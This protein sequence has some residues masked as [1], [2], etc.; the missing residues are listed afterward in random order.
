MKQHRFSLTNKGYAVPE[1]LLN[2]DEET[3]K[4]KEENIRK[5]SNY[6]SPSMIYAKQSIY[7]R[8]SSEFGNDQMSNKEINK[9]KY[10]EN[11]KK[12]K[13]TFSNMKEPRSSLG[14]SIL[15]ERRKTMVNTLNLIKPKVIEKKET[16]GIYLKDVVNISI[17]Y[18]KKKNSKN[19]IKK[20]YDSIV[21]RIKKT[22]KQEMVHLE[23][24]FEEERIKKHH[25]EIN[26]K[27]QLEK[28]S[29][30]PLFILNSNSVNIL[31][32]KATM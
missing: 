3:K 24:K 16:G 28:I 17:E 11:L 20:N 14:S 6:I 21:D 2:G 10:Q 29:G 15:Q 26:K 19:V 32:A 1:K 13:S 18:D 12:M 23:K 25:D 8:K 5:T 27:L 31:K 7:E 30:R 22:Q 9:R 4:I